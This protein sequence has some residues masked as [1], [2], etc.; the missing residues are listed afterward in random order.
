MSMLFGLVFAAIAVYRPTHPS[1]I[2]INDSFYVCSF[3]EL[4]V[5][6]FILHLKCLCNSTLLFGSSSLLF[7]LQLA[8]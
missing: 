4:W 2:S 5:I 8:C 7:L 3:V 1:F 6:L